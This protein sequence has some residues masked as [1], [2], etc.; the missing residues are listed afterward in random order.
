MKNESHSSSLQSWEFVVCLK[1]FELGQ[2]IRLAQPCNT[3]F[4]TQGFPIFLLPHPRP[5]GLCPCAGHLMVSTWLLGLQDSTSAVQEK[6]KSA[7]LCQEEK[8]KTFLEAK[9][10]RSPLSC[11]W[12]VLG[13]THCPFSP[14]PYHQN[15]ESF[16]KDKVA[17]KNIH[18]PR[19]KF[20]RCSKNKQKQDAQQGTYMLI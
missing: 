15:L 2:T 10:I 4:Q 14:L 19:L 8:D 11:S 7:H 5:L 13:H 20:S 3:P 17:I 6:V 1:R 9:P 18:L 12:R 16:Q